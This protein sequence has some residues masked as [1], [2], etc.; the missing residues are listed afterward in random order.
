MRR[1]NSA[2]SGPAGLSLI[3]L[4]IAVL[5]VT[6]ERIRFW[7]IWW[8]R[9][10]SL[11]RQWQEIVHQGER[12]AL[13]WLADR[14]QEMRF[15]QSF[16]EAAMV[17]A[18]LLGLIGTVLGL[19]RLLTAMGPQLLLPPGSGLSGFGDILLNTAM[20]LLVSL[21]ATV[22]WHINSGLRQRQLSFWQRE[23]RRASLPPGIG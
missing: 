20:G 9:R 16:L 10:P 5:T 11:Q 1:V 17:I 18:P 7:V 21:V 4:S 3:L 8:R 19:S 13:D 23:L 14:E 2:L 6:L 12:Q 15:A 22:T